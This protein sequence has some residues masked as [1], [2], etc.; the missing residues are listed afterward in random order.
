MKRDE[1]TKKR[2]DEDPSLRNS[3]PDQIPGEC[4]FVDMSCADLNP[5]QTQGVQEGEEALE[6]L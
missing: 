4:D 6:G 1:N 5:V 3:R 2:Y